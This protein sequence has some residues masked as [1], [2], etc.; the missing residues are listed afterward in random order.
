MHNMYQI[1]RKCI[2]YKT[3]FR[4]NLQGIP[5]K[6]NWGSLGHILAKCW[7]LKEDQPTQDWI[8]WT[9]NTNM[10]VSQN[11]FFSRFAMEFFQIL[12]QI[13]GHSL[14]AQRRS[15]KIHLLAKLRLFSF[16]SS[17][18]KGS[19]M[20]LILPFLTAIALAKVRIGKTHSNISQQSKYHV[21]SD[22]KYQCNVCIKM[23]Y[24]WCQVIWGTQ[25][26]RAGA[27]LLWKCDKHIHFQLQIS[28]FQYIQKSP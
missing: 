24:N 8:R 11:A 16:M 27:G 4:A 19:L 20:K 10:N 14:S 25:L 2:C 1:W 5:S 23:H 9:K 28:Y 13:Q 26:G 6:Y 3:L 18:G 12:D 22:Q 17:G 7:N 21:N 15:Y